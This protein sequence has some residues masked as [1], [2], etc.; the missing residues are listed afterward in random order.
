M[1]IAQVVCRFKPYKGGISNV[2]YD[3]ALGLSKLGHQVTVFTPLVDSKDNEVKFAEFEVRRLKP[4][5]SF[6]N[7]GFLPQLFWELRDFDLVN[8]HYPFFG[9]AEVVWLLKKYLGKKLKLVINYQ[10]DVVGSGWKKSIF[11][12]HTKHFMPKII[13]SADKVIVSSFD[14]AKNSNIKELII[15]RSDKFV[16]IPPSVNLNIFKPA[17]NDQILMKKFDIKANEKV[18]LFVGALDQAH[19]FKGIHFL[20]DSYKAI[21]LDNLKIIIVGEGDLKNE[22]QKHVLDLGLIDKIL[23]AGFAHDRELVNFYNLADA[24]ILPSIDKSEAFGIV[25]IEAM[26]C[27][28]P[29]LAAN[30]PGVRSVFE[31][32]VSGFTFEVLDQHDLVIKVRKIFTDDA[33]LS[34]FGQAAKERAEKMYSQDVLINK[35]NKVYEELVKVPPNL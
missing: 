6:G 4:L 13:A 24:I 25:L 27:A 33:L 31:N 20:I 29:V 30:L 2:A 28:K 35:L 26:A 14:Y 7:S 10:M 9:G 11:S 34:Q 32:R 8:L 12:F 19:Y 1:K 5:F 23:F 17:I 21:G 18:L 16:E 15:Q 3:Y 22:Y